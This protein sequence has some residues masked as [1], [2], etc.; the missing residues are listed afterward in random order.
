MRNVQRVIWFV[1][2]NAWTYICELSNLS[3]E[4]DNIY[5]GRCNFWFFLVRQEECWDFYSNSDGAISFNICSISF[6]M[7][8]RQFRDVSRLRTVLI[9]ILQVNKKGM[10]WRSWLMHC[11]KSRNVAGSIPDN[12]T[13]IFH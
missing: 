13:V 4:I 2:G 9:N 8:A 3:L 1:S 5:R 7:I 6:F 12:V 10:M 11:A